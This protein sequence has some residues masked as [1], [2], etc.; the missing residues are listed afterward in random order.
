MS[1][2]EG[3]ADGSCSV[4]KSSL[5]EVIASC[6]GLNITGTRG[7]HESARGFPASAG[8]S[9]RGKLGWGLGTVD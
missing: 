9:S 7:I 3:E 1:S 5:E 6:S 2:E 8:I 4:R